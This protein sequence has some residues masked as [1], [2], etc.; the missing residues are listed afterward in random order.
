MNRRVTDGVAGLVANAEALVAL[1]EGPAYFAWAD[2]NN[3][4]LKDAPQWREAYV[5]TKAAL[6]AI[7]KE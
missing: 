7:A 1:I 5:A 4:R 3:Y 6:A 2:G